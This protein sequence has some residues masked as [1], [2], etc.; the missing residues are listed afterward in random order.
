MKW[1][2]S[3]CNVAL[4]YDDFRSVRVKLQNQNNWIELVI[5]VAWCDVRMFAPTTFARKAFERLANRFRCVRGAH[6]KQP[7]PFAHSQLLTNRRHFAI[8]A[9]ASDTVQRRTGVHFCRVWW[10]RD[11]ILRVLFV[12]I[13]FHLLPS[14]MHMSYFVV[15]VYLS[16]HRIKHT[17]KNGG[18]M[19][20]N[21]CKTQHR[22]HIHI[23]TP[24]EKHEQRYLNSKL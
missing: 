9:S 18:A 10:N 13:S 16:R 2:K 14:F 1:K 17:L 6:A 8:A 23:H 15:A 11:C 4:W 22:T 19:E 3:C 24:N 12:F 20:H 21:E 7:F 5:G